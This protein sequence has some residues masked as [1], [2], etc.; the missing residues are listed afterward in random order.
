[1]AYFES[2]AF[3]K[4]FLNEEGSDDARQIWTLAAETFTVR[5]TYAEVRAAIAAAKRAARIDTRTFEAA[6][7]AFAVRFG[8]VSVIDA[9]D[10]VVRLA[11]DL[12]ERWSLRGYDAVHLGAAGL[13]GAGGDLVFVTWDRRLAE[14]ARSEGL[15]TAGI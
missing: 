7:K 10:R 14:A 11:G 6:K 5:I 12:A 13:A 9:G 8:D 4:L 2:S 1:M 3:L 15:R